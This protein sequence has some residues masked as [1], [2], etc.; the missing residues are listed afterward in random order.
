V[1][2]SA[3]RG[4]YN[5]AMASRPGFPESSNPPHPA[6]QRERWLEALPWACPLARLLFPS[7]P[8]DPA[9]ALALP[10]ENIP[11]DTAML[12]AYYLSFYE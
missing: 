4:L 11:E 3:C 12:S 7:C 6:G 8:V 5:L 2:V 9:R 10:P 1:L